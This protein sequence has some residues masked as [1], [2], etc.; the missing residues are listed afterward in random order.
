MKHQ[1]EEEKMRPTKTINN[2]IKQKGG[3]NNN[4][5]NTKSSHTFGDFV[6]F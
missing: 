3:N 5:V 2:Q 4:I 6:S 1:K